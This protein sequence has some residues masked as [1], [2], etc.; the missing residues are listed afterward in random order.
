MVISS[1]PP[2]LP[3][4]WQ[5][6]CVLS[7]IIVSPPKKCDPWTFVRQV[8]WQRNK[9]TC[10]LTAT[11]LPFVKAWMISFAYWKWGRPFGFIINHSIYVI[12]THFECHNL[13]FTRVLWPREDIKVV[14]HLILSIYL[15][16]LEMTPT[17]DNGQAGQSTLV[18]T[19]YIHN[20]RHVQ[21]LHFTLTKA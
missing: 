18:H 4:G 2:L 20:I 9:S 14:D 19:A 8:S 16:V 10:D 11:K 1:S 13:L 21:L 5:Y 12:T 3:E 15:R 7:V 6:L 17:Y